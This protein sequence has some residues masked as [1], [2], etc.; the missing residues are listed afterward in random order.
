MAD[1]WYVWLGN[2]NIPVDQPHGSY[3]FDGPDGQVF[4]VTWPDGMYGYFKN[5]EDFKDAIIVKWS[6]YYNNHLSERQQKRVNMMYERLK[7]KNL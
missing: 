1:Q 2:K 7:G 5:I 6:S 3:P 4:R